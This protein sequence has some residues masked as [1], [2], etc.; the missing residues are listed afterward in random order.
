MNNDY[1][2]FVNETHPFHLE[3]QNLSVARA[4]GFDLPQVQLFFDNVEALMKE[5]KF[6]MSMIWNVDETGG[7][8]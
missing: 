2:T 4:H 7:R 3:H 1:T 5:D 6:A 8:F